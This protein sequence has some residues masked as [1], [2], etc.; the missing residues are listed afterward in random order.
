MI[1]SIGL[2]NKGLRASS[3]HDLPVLAT[4][5]VPLIVSVAGFSPRGVRAAGREV[6]ER[7]ARS[8]RSS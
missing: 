4:L 7:A 1:N 6:A 5:P 3:Q 8:R 2:P